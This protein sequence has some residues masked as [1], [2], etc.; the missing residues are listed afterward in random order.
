ML[1]R[2]V[3]RLFENMRFQFCYH[4]KMFTSEPLPAPLG[5][6]VVSDVLIVRLYFD[7]RASVIRLLPE[8][9]IR[10]QR[11]GL[12]WVFLNASG[13]ASGSLSPLT[14]SLR[15]WTKVLEKKRRKTL[16]NLLSVT[17]RSLVLAR[18]L[19]CTSAHLWCVYCYKG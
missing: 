12:C 1:V 16:S 10:C 15:N 9:H 7:R 14:A 19:V 2:V 5:D 18:G 13:F 4:N 3:S 17:S 11:R 6:A 8:G